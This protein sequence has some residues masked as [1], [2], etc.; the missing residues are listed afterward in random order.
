MEKSWLELL[1]EVVLLNGRLNKICIG[2]GININQME[3]PGTLE[4]KATSLK[5]EFGKEFD[6]LEIFA[7]FIELFEK[8]YLKMIEE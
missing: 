1:Q 8:E 4:E 6:R 7:K 3:F 5:K 2:V